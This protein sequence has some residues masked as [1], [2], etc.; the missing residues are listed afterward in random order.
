MPTV[1]GE[2]ISP[3]RF[4]L[5]DQCRNNFFDEPLGHFV[6]CFELKCALTKLQNQN[7]LAK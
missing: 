6:I 5:R 7:V 1:P 2:R 3:L 4:G